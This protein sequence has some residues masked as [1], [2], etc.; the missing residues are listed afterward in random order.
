MPRKTKSDYTTAYLLTL[1]VSP[2]TK[3]EE[4]FNT[5]FE[6]TIKKYSVEQLMVMRGVI[7]DQKREEMQKIVEP[8]SF[9]DAMGG[10]TLKKTFHSI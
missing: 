1:G 5:I 2:E 4:E 10:S 3:G 8:T 9:V 6:E 7:L